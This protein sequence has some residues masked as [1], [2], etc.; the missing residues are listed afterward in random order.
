MGARLLPVLRGG[1]LFVSW[2]HFKLEEFSCKH[3]GENKMNEDFI[4][5]LDDLR[6]RCGFALNITSGYRCPEHNNRVSSTGLY[7]PHT[8]GRAVD[9]GV[10]GGLAL[11]VLRNAL[12]MQF[13]GFGVD[14]KGPSRFLHLDDLPLESYPRPAI[15]T[16]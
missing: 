1:E 12:N 5:K 13:T 10:R 8:T 9:I 2:K 11:I 14:Q 3:C 15:W 16:Y 7:G 6:H 4:W